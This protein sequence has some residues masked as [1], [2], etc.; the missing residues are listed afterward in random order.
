MRSLLAIS[1]LAA[2]AGSLLLGGAPARAQS[3][4]RT[5]EGIRVTVAGGREVMQ[6][7]FSAPVEAPPIQEHQPG[8][9]RLR[10]SATGSSLPSS[11]FQIKEQSTIQDYRVVR[12]QY[13][14]TV[15]VTLRDPRQNLEGQLIFER[16]GSVMRVILPAVGPASPSAAD[17]AILA[18]AERRLAGGPPAGRTESPAPPPAAAQQAPPLG[19][20]DQPA[21]FEENWLGTLLTMIVALAIVL[22]LLYA[23]VWAYNRFLAS[24]V[25]GRGGVYPIRHLGSYAVGPRQRVVVLDINGEVVA[26]GVTPQHVSFLAR[27]GASRQAAPPKPAPVPAG[28]SD[29]LAAGPAM[30]RAAMSQDAMAA[31]NPAAPEGAAKDPAKDPVHTFAETLKEKVRSLKRLK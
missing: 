21:A 30:P 28:S 3:L 18:Q 9:F 20:A 29:A 24:R 11:Q 17:Q 19:K 23:L 25:A 16:D 22:G 15:T 12:N 2:L 6:L 5:L 1:G 8:A 27:L 31:P 26:C 13:A 7:T 14:T 10:F 4:S